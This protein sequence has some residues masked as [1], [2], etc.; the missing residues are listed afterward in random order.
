MEALDEICGCSFESETH[1][2]L[3]MRRKDQARIQ[4]ARC[5]AGKHSLDLR[6]GAVVG[7]ISPA[8]IAKKNIA[9]VVQER[10][11]AN[12]DGDQAEQALQA[13]NGICKDD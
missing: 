12:L 2:C 7:Q 1:V 13:L 8:D 5:L 3:C 6:A 4:C 11:S 9:H 10:L